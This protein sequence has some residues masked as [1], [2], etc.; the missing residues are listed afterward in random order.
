MLI[1]GLE[2]R[3]PHARKDSNPQPAVLETAAPP[4]LERMKEMTR[5]TLCADWGDAAAR[6]KS[7][8]YQ[9][10]PGLPVLAESRRP[11]SCS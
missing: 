10:P 6:R 1:A 3:H 9:R 11:S 4:R 5:M 8:Y 2:A 7:R